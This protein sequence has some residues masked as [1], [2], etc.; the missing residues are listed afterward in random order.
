MPVCDHRF[1]NVSD[2]AEYSQVKIKYVRQTGRKT[3]PGACLK[4]EGLLYPFGMPFI[5]K[6]ALRFDNENT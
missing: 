3:P 6:I 2:G 5:F 4:V 1:V